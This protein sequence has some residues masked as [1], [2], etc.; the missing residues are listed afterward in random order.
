MMIPVGKE[1]IFHGPYEELRDRIGTK[2]IVIG[3]ITENTPEVNFDEVGPMYT[4]RFEDGL[5]TEAWPEEVE[6]LGY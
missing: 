5:Q 3:H 6:N 1:F 2:A 4:I